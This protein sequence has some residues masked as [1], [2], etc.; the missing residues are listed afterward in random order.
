M[1]GRAI[2][3]LLTVTGIGPTLR[4]AMLVIRIAAILAAVVVGLYVAGFDPAAAL[5]STLQDWLIPDGVSW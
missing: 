2:S 1:I 4:S 5:Q 3:V